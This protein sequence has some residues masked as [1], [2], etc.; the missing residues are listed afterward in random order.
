MRIAII[1]ARGGSKRVPRKNMLDVGGRPMVTYPIHCALQS[2]LFDEVYVS[3]EDD[4]IAEIARLAKASV[5]DRPADIA[6]DRS[7][8]VEV[9]T[10]ALDTL[11]ARDVSVELFCCI[12]ATAIFITPEDLRASLSMLSEEPEADVVM[13][14]SEFAINP[15]KALKRD[16]VFWSHMWPEFTN[17]KSQLHPHLVASNGTLYWARTT[18][19]R[20]QA[21]FYADRLKC[22]ELPDERAVDIDTEVDLARAR[23]LM[24]LKMTPAVR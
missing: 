22:Y 13:G 7:T 8:V 3:T 18:P 11:D 5:I 6:Q 23:R 2:E 20:T 17:M 19:F 12:Y 1:P 14:V 9:C 10:H 15:V 4:E 16:G 24:D 21:T